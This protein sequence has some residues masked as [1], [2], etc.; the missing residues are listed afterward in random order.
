MIKTKTK[1]RTIIALGIVL[2]LLAMVLPRTRVLAAEET[3]TVEGIDMGTNNEPIRFSVLDRPGTNINVGRRIPR[4]I[5]RSDGSTVFCLEPGVVLSDGK[6]LSQEA[7]DADLRAWISANAPTMQLSQENLNLIERIVY[8]GWETSGQEPLDY[9]ATQVVLWEKLWNL[10]L[11][12]SVYQELEDKMDN[13]EAKVD[14]HYLLPKLSGSNYD[15]ASN[16]LTI[17]PGETSNLTDSSGLIGGME[18]IS[19]DTGIKTS[20]SGN[21]ISLTAD[22]KSKNGT[23]KFRKHEVKNVH[24][25]IVYFNISG[26][27]G[28][29]LGDLGDP[30]N[31]FFSLNVRMRTRGVIS[32]T[33]TNEL[34][35][36][37]DGAEFKLSR[38]GADVGIKQ[39]SPGV[40]TRDANSNNSFTTHNGKVLIQDLEAGT[41]TITETKSPNGFVSNTKPVQVQVQDE[42]TTQASMQNQIGKA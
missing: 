39:V 4:I 29:R 38:D 32:F 27:D 41:Y 28:Q 18:L 11:N 15:A 33:K 17:Y 23:L 13:L 16:T 30:S 36:N 2:I 35:A 34:G 26:E 22:N 21:K 5:K 42:Q 6:Y 37:L 3:F 20:L 7:L 19:N 12:N 8:H 10:S 31:A 1:R 14:T 25:S 24:A 40:Y 9:A